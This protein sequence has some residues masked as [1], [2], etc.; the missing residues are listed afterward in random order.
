MPDRARL[1]QYTGRWEDV[2]RS[3]EAN[4]RSAAGA[5]ELYGLELRR[6]ANNFA[7]NEHGGSSPDA[8]ARVV[9]RALNDRNPRTR[10]PAS[11]DSLKLT[12]LARLLPEKLLD[13]AVLKTFGLLTS[14]GKR[15]GG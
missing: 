13:F 5:R 10:Y 6:M 12:I 3:G 9:E 7:K 4:I 11:K 15:I 8:V 1:D 2:G 14:F